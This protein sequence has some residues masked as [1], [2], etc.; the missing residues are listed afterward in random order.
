[1]FVLYTSL[2]SPQSFD[3]NLLLSEGETFGG[4][5]TVRKED[6]HYYTPDAAQRSDDDKLE[7][8]AGEASPDA[9]DAVSQQ[10]T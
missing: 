10:T 9:A 5:W 7:L 6:Y 1:M 8:P 4:D 2:V 3:G